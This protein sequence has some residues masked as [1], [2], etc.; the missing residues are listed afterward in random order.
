MKVKMRTW[1]MMKLRKQIDRFKIQKIPKLSVLLKNSKKLLFQFQT[2]RFWIVVLIKINNKLITNSVKML[3]MKG[4]P[5][6]KNVNIWKKEKAVKINCIIQV[7]RT[8]FI[9]LDWWSRL[10]LNG[11]LRTGSLP[12]HPLKSLLKA[13][14]L[15]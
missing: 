14:V 9:K 13:N 2:F 1:V 10:Y 12:Q 4:W 3:T 5:T 7:L 8:K 11:P 6:D 15:V